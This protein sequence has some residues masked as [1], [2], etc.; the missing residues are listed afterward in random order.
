[1][2]DIDRRTQRN[3]A[4]VILVTLEPLFVVPLVVPLPVQIVGSVV[5]PRVGGRVPVKPGT[6]LGRILTGTDSVDLSVLDEKREVPVHIVG[7]F[8]VLYRERHH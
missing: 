6:S 8:A 3:G 2:T 7:Q 1:M 5:T 4:F